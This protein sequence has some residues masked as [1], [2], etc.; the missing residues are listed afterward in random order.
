MADGEAKIIVG[1]SP[2]AAGRR[3][4]YLIF[5]HADGR[6]EVLRGGPDRR[7]EGNDLANLA[8][9][10]LLG[11][12]NFGNIRVDNA[13]YEP[14]Y[15]AV[16]TQNAD[17]SVTPHPADKADLKDPALLRDAQG[18]PIRQTEVSPDWPLAGEHHERQTVWTGSEADMQA[19]LTAARQAG[20]QINDAQLEYSPLYN[21]SNGV[22]SNL[23]KAAGVEPAL[24]KDQHGAAVNAPDFGDDLYK[25]VGL[26]SHRSGNHF[27][28]TQW[29]D[30]DNRPIQPPKSDQPTVP[31]DPN[32]EPSHGSFDSRSS[33][34]PRADADMRHADHPD[35]AMYRQ[36]Y[37][38]VATF[39]RSIGRT[40]DQHTEQLA[41]AMTAQSKADGLN[42]IGMV[43]MNDDRSRAYAVDG[44]NPSDPFRKHSS[45][46]VAQAANQPV[47]VSNR[48][49]NETNAQAQT[50]QQTSI[51]QQSA[52]QDGP[53]MA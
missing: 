44:T 36:A 48:Q 25:D 6:Q 9:S 1:A 18:A 46:D 14:P 27:N 38:G 47:D 13:P 52:Q 33:G 43:V 19:K 35:Q 17:G 8:G 30:N 26:A 51:Q 12:N 50:A 37:D 15:S 45:V 7:S 49:L 11:S 2:V 16:Y 21:N 53:R 39:D 10:T 41:A 4:T 34:G 5:E 3:H 20:Q 40:P 29:F 22:T 24:P 32:R 31:L 23:M 42:G 28:G